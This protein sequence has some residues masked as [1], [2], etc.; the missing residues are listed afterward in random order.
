M[1]DDA[2]QPNCPGCPEWGRA[3]RLALAPFISDNLH[4]TLTS[5]LPIPLLY[6][7]PTTSH[8][9]LAMMKH[10]A[11]LL[12]FARGAIIDR[13]VGP[14]AETGR[15]SCMCMPLQPSTAPTPCV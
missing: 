6:P 4:H 8:K 5:Q 15:A 1:G 12:N 11:Y 7:L 9:E 3:E 2:Q 13:Q 14:D 10:G